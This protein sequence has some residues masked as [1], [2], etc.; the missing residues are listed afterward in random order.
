KAEGFAAEASTYDN[1]LQAQAREYLARLKSL[2]DIYVVRPHVA[3]EKPTP[4]TGDGRQ[5]W[6]K[7]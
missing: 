7:E 6:R 4:I 2:W 5:T 1:T 3:L